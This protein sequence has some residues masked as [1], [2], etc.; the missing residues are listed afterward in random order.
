M[1]TATTRRQS[2]A[3][4]LRAFFVL[5]LTSLGLGAAAHAHA[6]APAP[7]WSIESLAMPTNFIPG[8]TTR[9]YRYTVIAMN[10]GG[11][12]TDGSPI[13]L[14]DTLPLGLTVEKV[15]LWMRTPT[16]RE[17]F[18]PAFCQTEEPP[19]L[20]ALVTCTVPSEHSGTSPEPSRVH[21]SEALRMVIHLDV[22]PGTPQ[23]T[24]RNEVEVRGG[25]AA[26][27]TNSA[28]NATTSETEPRPAE[29]GLS[30]FRAAL[31][32][33]DG[34]PA[35]RAGSR[36]YQYVTTYAVNTQA[37]E[38]GADV[39][40]APAG[41]D[42][43]D[44]QVA[45]PPGLVGNPSATSRCT[46][47]QFTTQSPLSDT[48]RPLNNCPDGSAVGLVYAQVVS[49]AGEAGST[50]DITAGFPVPLYNLV[51][52]KGMPAQFGFQVLGA[53]F[54]INTKVRTGS[55]YGITASLSN[56]TQVRRVIGASVVVWG[57]PSDPSHD[58]VRGSCL[59]VA[60]EGLPISFGSCPAGVPIRPFLRMPTSCA[61]P[62]GF[63]MAVDTWAARGDFFSA[64]SVSPGLGGCATLPFSPTISVTPDTTVADSP[65]GLGV[66]LRLP[67]EESPGFPGTADLRDATVTLPRGV[68]VNPAQASGLAACSPAEIGLTSGP[69]ASPATF[70]EEPA[71]CPDASKIGE[72]EIETPLLDHPVSGSVYVA[73]QEDNPFASL[74]AIYI[75]AHD[76]QTGVVVKLAGRVEPDR[77]T[78]Q[79]TT[80]FSDNPQL[81]FSEFHV[82]FFSGPRAALRTPST[83]GVY[84]TT[85]AMKPWSAPESGPDAT[86]SDRFEVTV[87]PGGGRCAETEAGQ[88][89][90]PS[91]EAGTQV[92][93]A[94]EPS[95]F[96]MRLKR[97]D[98]SQTLRGLNLRLPEGLVGK[99]AGVP[100]CSEAAIGQA[101]S[102]T[103][104]GEGKLE[105]G[106]PSCPAASQIGSATAGAGA[107][108][109]P[110]HVGGK[111]Y[112]TGP[113]K[114]APLGVAVI[115]PAVAGPFDL[116]TVVVRAALRVDPVTTR[117]SAVSDPLP[118]ILHGIP[119]ALKTV[120]LDIDRPDF[121]RNP[122]S[123]EP[124]S[125]EGE[126]LSLAGQAASLS[127]RFQVGGCRGLGFKPRLFLRLFGG[128]GRDAHPRLRAVL[129]PR[130]GDANIARAV[131]AL[132]HSEFLDQSNIRTVC[133]RVQ[134]AADQCP[135]GAIYGR[136]VA[137][138]PL[139]DE[140]L[141]GP[142]YLRS[143]NNLLPD[144]VVALRGQIEVELSGRIDS[145]RGGI[146]TTFEM[147]PDAP[148][149]KFILTMQGGRKKGLLVNSQNLC[150]T[151]NRAHVAFTGH[152]GRA[153]RTRPE[154]RNSRCDR[155]GK[156][157]AGNH[158]RG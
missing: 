49:E 116:G 52:P 145:V 75:A 113:Y 140:P 60:N 106:S 65:S 39:L 131:V 70:S 126:A 78:G 98:G 125:V 69:G 93:V 77:E 22:P 1:S 43:K 147:A 15:E 11:S 124:M 51:P 34:S 61:G 135:A 154:L 5:A 137:F 119:L 91:F 97:E 71:R 47:Q 62:L 76:E 25:G 74:L 24:L 28:E 111:V 68:T 156:K 155:G 63:T 90:R 94:G 92:P 136:A 115:T 107:G 138:S 139:L 48:D 84:T 58:A 128:V 53:V 129:M 56:L 87:A 81:P 23:E 26:A 130:P 20:P 45:L 57:T 108:P 157:S 67:Q 21:P 142:V 148:V 86:P 72:V 2:P 102:R 14:S 96:L 41:G 13:V 152:N 121:T 134:F 27:V 19:G 79:L 35:D 6:A 149:S 9:D 123:C 104:P 55:D 4:R 37:T 12:V 118:T 54:Y 120:M 7:A 153:V 150:A 132:P 122:T 103:R 141:R 66:D 110:V 105:Q 117:V 64:S 158:R 151:V 3:I 73:A 18:G 50:T 88:P 30:Y 112:L 101:A 36:P 99:L 100:Y 82:N 146:R 109:S 29:A 46:A 38:P 42:T 95:P 10:V 143:S 80:T 44:V 144:L 17:D 40:F 89:H 33:A 31:L 133:T 8:D 59:N 85:T 83:C 32:E 16:K 114:G 127:S